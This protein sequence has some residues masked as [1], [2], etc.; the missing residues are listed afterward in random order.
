MIPALLLTVA[1]TDTPKAPGPPSPARSTAAPSVAPSSGKTGEEIAQVAVPG[2][3]TSLG[4]GFGSLWVAAA[5]DNGGALARVDPVT[6]RVLATITVGGFPI[7]IAAGFGSIWQANYQDGTLSRVDPATNKVIAT[8]PVGP[9]PAQVVTA[10]GLVWVGDEDSTLAAVDPATN[11]QAHTV[12]VG[13][14]NKFRA[15]ATSSGSLWT[16]NNG[17]GVSRLD[18]TTGAVVATIPIAGCC[19]GDLLFDHGLLWASNPGKD[20]VYRIDPGTNR[21]VGH[22][23]VAGTPRGLTIT[24]GRL[25]ISHG[26]AGTVSWHT[27]DSGRELGRTLLGGFVGSMVVT[28]PTSVWVMTQDRGAVTR[29]AVGSR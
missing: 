4:T 21:V 1:C 23:R 26:D 5:Q 25:W 9:G 28:D 2:A 22:F 11:R 12:H 27:I 7:G 15:L 29:V 3:P 24:G 6:N 13:R 8:I 14:G 18:P 17:G 19:D 10:G 16:D 20:R